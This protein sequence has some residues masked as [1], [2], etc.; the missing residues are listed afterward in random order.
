MP[1]AATSVDQKVL[2]SIFDGMRQRISR[3]SLRAAAVA[4]LIQAA[5]F[6]LILTG[7]SGAPISSSQNKY[8]IEG[9]SREERG[10]DAGA[11][12]KYTQAIWDNPR[13]H[14]A[15]ARR[16]SVYVKKG[17]YGKAL[18]DAAQSLKLSPSGINYYNRGYIYQKMGMEEEA[19]SDFKKAVELG[20]TPDFPLKN[21][22]F[23]SAMLNKENGRIQE[24]AEDLTRAIDIDSRFAQAYLERGEIYLNHGLYKEA[25]KD[26]TVALKH[27]RDDNIDVRSALIDQGMA[28][29]KSGMVD[30]ARTN[31]L[32]VI[33]LIPSLSVH[34]GEQNAVDLYDDGKFNSVIRSVADLGRKAEESRN[35]SEAFKVYEVGLSWVTS[36][37]KKETADRLLSGIFRVYP[38][39]EEKPPVPEEAQRH[40]IIALAM[41]SKKLYG[42]AIEAYG[43]LL[44][45]SPWLPE[46]Y[47]NRALLHAEL[48]EYKNAAMN[49]KQYLE[50][51]PGSPDAPMAQEKLNEWESRIKGG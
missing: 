33:S 42:K 30:K 27:H 40:E 46:A 31:A 22:Y 5:I 21:L 34:F 32:K 26:F 3:M 4:Y 44:R 45:V 1:D 9:V 11:I 20:H 49:M 24:A 18:A 12:M 43:R 8:L 14:L 7:C 29:Y 50:L 10:D 51:A 15:Y 48:G 47:F 36:Y 28:F 19:I 2:P 25:V 16:S 39:L 37:T 41:T 13:E 38:R 35:W 17:L 23:N 6:I